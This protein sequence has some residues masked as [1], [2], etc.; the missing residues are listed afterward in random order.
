[1]KKKKT[2][3]I[4]VVL[5][6]LVVLGFVL[7]KTIGWPVDS[8]NASGN[9]AK[10]SHFSR[11]TADGNIG[12]MQELLQNDE[13]FKNDIVTAYVVM[14]TRAEQF[15]A[16]VNMSAEVAGDIPEFEA[17][18]KAMKEAQPMIKNVCASMETAGK[19]LDS[20]LGGGETGDLE[21]NTSNAALA[22]N[23]LQK[24]NKL[25]TQF[26]ETADNYQKKADDRLKFVR[27]QWVDYQQMTAAITQD[28]QLAQELDKRG[29]QLS[30]AA[31]VKALGSF[32]KGMQ[33]SCMQ[34]S[35]LASR[36]D[37]GNA[38]ANSLNGMDLNSAIQAGG[39]LKAVVEN[40]LAAV[41]DAKRLG[42]A[43]DANGLG[44]VA[45]AKRLGRAADANGL[46]A[47]ADAKRL[48]RAADANGLGAVA[49]AKRLGAVTDATKLGAL[50]HTLFGVLSN[51]TLGGLT[52][53]QGT[54]QGGLA[55]FNGGA[56]VL[57]MSQMNG[58]I[59]AIAENQLNA[60]TA[61]GK[62]LNSRVKGGAEE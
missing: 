26:I 42:R 13:D 25:A 11:K 54:L 62:T 23:T 6:A 60:I 61:G 37:V 45:D 57:E 27:D 1:M 8:E 30:D 29:Y 43:A 39:V 2:T 14:K 40:G 46:G 55:N 36:C 15:N 56:R 34:G 44:A 47:V 51:T 24:Q 7:S 4:Y 10:S 20:A 21:Q 35:Y 58:V 12:N 32:D 33:I 38:L 17:V 5:A 31:R 49:D 48:G 59:S 41:A 28:K 9:I 16:L 3:I 52:N 50:A 18:L 22:Y 53:L 19:D